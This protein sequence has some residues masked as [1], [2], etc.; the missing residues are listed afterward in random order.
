MRLLALVLV[1][2]ACAPKPAPATASATGAERPL[3]V[4][5]ARKGDAVSHVMGTCHLAIPL[6]HALPP[7]HDAHLREAR[8]LLS[9]LD[10]H[11]AVAPL[12]LVKVMWQPDRDLR[13]QLG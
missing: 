12:E 10:L 5:E 13:A 1:L 7:P 9:E 4:W 8:V 3:L 2:A 6:A 11:A